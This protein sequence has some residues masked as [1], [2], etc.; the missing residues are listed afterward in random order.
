MNLTAC[1]RV[2]ITGSREWAGPEAWVVMEGLLAQLPKDAV[3]VHG[4]ARGADSMA[5]TAASNLGLK[6]ERHPISRSD[7]AILGTSAGP[8]R[9]QEMVNLGADVCLAFPTESSR[10]TWDCVRRA[11]AA[12][13]PVVITEMP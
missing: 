8:A 11:E 7:W 6:R 9:N 12:G 3:V 10:G 13:I 4:A 1:K 5:D 2:L